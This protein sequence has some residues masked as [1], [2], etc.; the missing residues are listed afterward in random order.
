MRTNSI[1]WKRGA[2]RMA[3]LVVL[4]VAAACSGDQVPTGPGG[5]G[6]LAVTQRIRGEGA[7]ATFLFGKP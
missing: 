6:G 2:G 7:P 5:G 3:A 4:A 1:Q